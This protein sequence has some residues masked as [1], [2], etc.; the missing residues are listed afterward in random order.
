MSV[1][2]R[3]YNKLLKY[4]LTKHLCFVRLKHGLTKS[5]LKGVS[6]Q[7]RVVNRLINIH[8]VP[9]LRHIPHI[10]LT[11]HKKR[12]RRKYFNI[13]RYMFGL[14]ILRHQVS[15]GEI[16]SLK[17][18]MYHYHK[19]IVTEWWWKVLLLQLYIHNV[20]KVILCD[21]IYLDL[22][23]IIPIKLSTIL[24]TLYSFRVNILT[25]C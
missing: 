14:Y 16:I 8:I 11:L 21:I 13:I 24:I 3:F 9:Y 7:R 18:H 2:S 19:R 5:I 12:G 4:F 1:I 25:T 15:G 17:Q 22:L 20:V 10:S 23:P 6:Q